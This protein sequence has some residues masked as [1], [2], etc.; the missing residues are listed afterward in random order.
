MVSEN[1]SAF[2]RGQ[3]PAHHMWQVRKS[4]ETLIL[5]HQ[6]EDRRKRLLQV[7]APLQLLSSLFKTSTQQ[8]LD[9]HFELHIFWHEESSKSLLWA[10]SCWKCVSAVLNLPF[11][12]VNRLLACSTTGSRE[13]VAADLRHQ[14]GWC[15]HI[16]LTMLE[17]LKLYK[18]QVL[19]YRRIKPQL[20]T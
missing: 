15:I 8:S 19:D 12:W 1:D 6:H 18:C 17:K 5:V 20:E 16:Y 11:L 14:Q 7:S 3:I 13:L 2:D 9:S 10:T 4:L